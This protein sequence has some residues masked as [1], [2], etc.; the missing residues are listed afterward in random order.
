MKYSL[1]HRYSGGSSRDGAIFMTTLTII[2]FLGMG[3]VAVDQIYFGGYMTG[4]M[5]KAIMKTAMEG[6]SK[7]IGYIFD[8]IFAVGYDDSF[9]EPYIN[10]ISLVFP[11]DLLFFCLSG[12]LT[13]YTSFIVF[14][15]SVKM[16][17]GA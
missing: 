10:T 4:N 16:L 8:D 2:A 14:R 17:R 13:F 11:V 3:G 15:Y 5:M 9:I 12:Y 7:I 1:M 6:G